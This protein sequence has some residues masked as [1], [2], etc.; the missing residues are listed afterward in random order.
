MAGRVLWT[1]CKLPQFIT[2]SEA[3][4]SIMQVGKLRHKVIFFFPKAQRGAAV[5]EAG[6]S[7]CRGHVLKLLT[8][9][10]MVPSSPPSHLIAEEMR[11]Q[12]I[13]QNT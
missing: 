4:I 5:F 9:Q 1:L 11:L 2:T 13:T 6:Q 3:G 8:G 12:G 7:G 10:T